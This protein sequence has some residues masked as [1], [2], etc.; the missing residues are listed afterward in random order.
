MVFLCFL[1][2]FYPL[3]K[4]ML[5]R[6]LL[7]RY[8]FSV[9]IITRCLFTRL[10]FQLQVVRPYLS[11]NRCFTTRTVFDYM[12]PAWSSRVYHNPVWL[13]IY[14]STAWWELSILN[15][16]V[17]TLTTIKLVSQQNDL[18]SQVWCVSYFII[19][20]TLVINSGFILGIIT[21]PAVNRQGNFKFITCRKQDCLKLPMSISRHSTIWTD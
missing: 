5:N 16:W 18:I 13:I 21:S 15:I 19:F 9:I 17:V 3:I 11:S 8:G 20:T 12:S 14:T 10:G 6:C 7:T 2:S 4:F 1:P